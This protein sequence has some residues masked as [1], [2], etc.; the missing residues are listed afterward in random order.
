MEFALEI[1]MESERGRKTIQ[2]PRPEQLPGNAGKDID[3]VK[4]LP[5]EHELPWNTGSQT[6]PHV[7]Q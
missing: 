7:R 2:W 4:H 3:E 1:V 6:N 5:E